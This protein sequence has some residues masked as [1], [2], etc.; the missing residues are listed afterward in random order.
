MHGYSTD[1]DERR[2]IPLFLASAAI[3]L[4]WLSSRFLAVMHLSLPWWIDAPSSMAYYGLLYVLFDRKLWRNRFVRKFGLVRVPNLTG[5]WRGYLVTSF[6]G[7]M[8]RH[9]L[10]LNI[11]QSW[12]QIVVYLTTETSMSRSCTAVL[13]VDDPDGLALVYQYQNQPL[14]N[15]TR[16]M[17]MH[18]GTAMLRMSNED[19]LIG[20]YYAGRDRRTFGRIC[21]W[22]EPNTRSHQRAYILELACEEN[23]TLQGS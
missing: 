7:H 20:D 14:A 3:A 12:T 10:V 11:F 18:F 8:K 6:D 4:A 23:Y 15:A 5:R 1:S 16:T 9:P 19:N 13:Q 2:V 22:K 21:C 17:H